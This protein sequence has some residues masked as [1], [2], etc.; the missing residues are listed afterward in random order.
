MTTQRVAYFARGSDV[1]TV[2]VQGRILMEERVPLTVDENE[3]LEWA[4]AEAGHTVEVFGLEPMMRRDAHYW[5][6]GRH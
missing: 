6:S 1:E 4:E 5:K 3:M 2:M